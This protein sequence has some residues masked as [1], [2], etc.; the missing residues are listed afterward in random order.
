MDFNE[1][2]FIFELHLILLKRLKS[3]VD[4]VL[5]AGH[6]RLAKHISVARWLFLRNLKLF[7]KN[8]KDFL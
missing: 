4:N 6:M 2:L 8:Q 7:L 3:S 5:L 1:N